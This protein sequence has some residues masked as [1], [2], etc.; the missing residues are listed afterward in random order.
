MTPPSALS[1]SVI[2]RSLSASG[3]RRPSWLRRFLTHAYHGLEPRNDHLEGIGRQYGETRAHRSRHSLGRAGAAAESQ[4][5]NEDD[6]LL[7]PSRPSRRCAIHASPDHCELVPVHTLV[8][9]V[10]LHRPQAELLNL[11]RR[12]DL[13][14]PYTLIRAILRLTKDAVLL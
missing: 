3:R 12:E 14:V 4:D 13:Y 7:L 9:H 10:E 5:T 1:R 2:G 6:E 8:V 11:C